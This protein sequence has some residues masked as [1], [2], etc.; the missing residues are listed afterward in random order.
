MACLY[1]HEECNTAIDKGNVT[2]NRDDRCRGRDQA[3][4]QRLSGG[5]H[6]VTSEGVPWVNL[7]GP[8]LVTMLFLRGASPCSP[9]MPTLSLATEFDLDEDYDHV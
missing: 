4:D 1:K 2:G 7:R 6:Q 8:G 3:K 5:V 9:C